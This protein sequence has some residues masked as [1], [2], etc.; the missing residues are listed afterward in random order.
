MRFGRHSIDRYASALN[1]LIPRY[2][3]R[4]KDPICEAVDALHLLYEN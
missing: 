4:W 1:T 2:N 3:A